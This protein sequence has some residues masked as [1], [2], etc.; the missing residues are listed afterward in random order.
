MSLSLFV[1]LHLFSFCIAIS[2][3]LYRLNCYDCSVDFKTTEVRHLGHPMNDT[4][5]EMAYKWQSEKRVRTK[6]AIKSNNAIYFYFI[7]Y[8]LCVCAIFHFQWVMY[9]A[10]VLRFG[11]QGTEKVNE[12]TYANTYETAAAPASMSN[13]NCHRKSHPVCMRSFGRYICCTLP[14]DYIS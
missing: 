7:L 12:F 3:L 10:S 5:N 4:T 11:L 8:F 1:R 6:S 2:R 9:L 14:T 13:E